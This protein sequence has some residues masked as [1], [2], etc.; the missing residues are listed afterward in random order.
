MKSWNSHRS[1]TPSLF[2][3][4]LA[5]ST[6]ASSWLILIPSYLIIY[7]MSS[8]VTFPVLLRS[9]VL[10]IFEGFF[11]E[12]YLQRIAH[13]MSLTLSMST[14]PSTVSQFLIATSCVSYSALA[15]SSSLCLEN[16]YYDFIASRPRITQGP[17][18]D[19]VRLIR[20]ELGRCT[21][22]FIRTEVQCWASI[23]PG[24]VARAS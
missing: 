2:T 23:V 10:N 5:S 9:H 15:C 18:D 1:N 12:A 21:L 3:S 20:F 6:F 19:P 17:W 24:Y 16:L 7:T 8:A 11:L 13:R 22:P 4:A 14:F